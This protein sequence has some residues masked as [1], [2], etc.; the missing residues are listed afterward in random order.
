[1]SNYSIAIK[2]VIM[3]PW[4][5]PKTVRTNTRLLG[6]DTGGELIQD[7]SAKAEVELITENAQ[8]HRLEKI[9]VIM[10]V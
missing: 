6:K 8:K 5:G 1:M 3:N 9:I 4:E 7:A 2:P 10:F